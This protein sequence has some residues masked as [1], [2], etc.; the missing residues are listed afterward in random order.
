METVRTFILP[1][2]V[3]EDLSDN[4]YRDDDYEDEMF[5]IVSDTE[6]ESELKR[7]LVDWIYDDSEDTV[8]TNE[9]PHNPAT[10]LIYHSSTHE[11]LMENMYYDEHHDGHKIYLRVRNIDRNQLI[12]QNTCKINENAYA[13][14]LAKE[15]VRVKIGDQVYNV[16]RVEISYLWNDLY[17]FFYKQKPI[18]PS[19]KANVFVYFNYSYYCNNKVNWTIPE[20]QE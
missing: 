18:C 2:D 20:A 15:Q 6:S 8:K 1:M 13:C 16:S 19:E 12:D 9:I 5:S 14:N 7:D 17:L 10:I 3:D 4:N 11:I